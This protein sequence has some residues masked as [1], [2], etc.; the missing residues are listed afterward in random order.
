M[1]KL[2]NNQHTSALFLG[3]SIVK[4]VSLEN[5]RYKVLES[6]YYNKFKDTVFSSTKNNGKFGLTSEKLLGSIG[7]LQESEPDI[8]FISIGANDCNY[9][10]KEISEQPEGKHLPAIEKNK[11]EDNLCSIYDYFLKNNVST[12]S[13]NFPPL[14]AEKFFNFLSSKL[15]GDNILKWLGNISRIYYHHESYNNIFETVTRTY[16]I[17]LIDIRSRFLM[18]DNLEDLI[19]VDGMH[20]GAAGHDLIYKSITDHLLTRAIRQNSGRVA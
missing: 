10:W 12:I 15:S 11:F 18:D 8:V 19:G 5:G 7:K 17:D 14:H 6:S 3:D 20:P 9:N 16:G 2:V 13:L 4:G 1:N